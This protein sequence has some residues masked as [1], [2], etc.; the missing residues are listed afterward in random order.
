MIQSH[1]S[2]TTVITKGIELYFSIP[3]QD[4]NNDIVL[5]SMI[6]EL[7]EQIKLKDYQLELKNNDKSKELL[8]TELQAHNETL[9][10]ELKTLNK[11]IIIT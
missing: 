11:C 10:R 4:N 5:K 8:I 7:Q 3:K 6:T 2:Q 9:K 1:E